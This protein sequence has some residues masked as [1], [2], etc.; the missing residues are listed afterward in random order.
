MPTRLS[1]QPLEE[2]VYSEVMIPYQ[3]PGLQLVLSYQGDIIFDEAYGLSDISNNTPASTGNYHRIASVSKA[4]TRGCIDALISRGKLSSD[5][6][7]FEILSEFDLAKNPMCKQITVEHCVDH[8]VG[9]W[10][11][12]ANGMD[13]MFNNA[14]RMQHGELI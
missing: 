4:V 12:V 6:K 2:H 11:T 7:V 5:Q 13:P 3:I 10:D 14:H 9:I 1:G 8:M